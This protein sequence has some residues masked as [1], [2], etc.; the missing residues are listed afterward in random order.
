MSHAHAVIWLDHHEARIIHFNAESSA[1]EHIKHPGDSHLNDFYHAIAQSLNTASEILVTG[2]GLA[3]DEFVKHIKAHDP[4]VAE[5][6]MGVEAADH[7]SDG[8]ILAH[9]RTFFKAKDKM[10]AH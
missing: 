4:K 1:N 8:Q 6:V 2:P 10:L 9:A 7:P 3:K 5:K